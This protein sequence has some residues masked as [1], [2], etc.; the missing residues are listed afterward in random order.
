MLHTPSPTGTV[1]VQTDQIDGETDWK[2][3]E[4]IRDTKSM[5]D[6][7]SRLSKKSLFS[8]TVGS[9]VANMTH[10][11]ARRSRP[12]IIDRVNY[13][14]IFKKHWQVT[15]DAPSSSIYE[16]SGSYQSDGDISEPLGI[17]NAIWANMKTTTEDMLV[18]VVYTGKETRIVLNS[19]KQVDKQGKTDIEINFLFKAFFGVIVIASLTNL[20][21]S[22]N[23]TDLMKFC[24]ILACILPFMLKFDT[25]VAK[26]YYSYQIEKD[27]SIEETIVRNRQI[28]EE[29]G[30]IEYLL[31]D[32]TGT[33]TRNEMIFKT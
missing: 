22:W 11:E 4:S 10:T 25:D 6:G 15:V 31:S 2:V 18:V 26:L 5:V 28:P 16:F 20:Y 14:T 24:I 3:R 8:S 19:K 9:I 23:V 1:Y 32:K 12:T 30:R 7:T 13:P 21:S 29:L 33:L 27:E 17:S